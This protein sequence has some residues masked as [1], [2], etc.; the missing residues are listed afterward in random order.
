RKLKRSTVSRVRGG[1]QT[2]AMRFD[3]RAADRQAQADSCLL[4]RKK[5]LE[6]MV[7][8]FW[9]ESAAAIAD[10][11]QN[12]A[13]FGCLCRDGKLS[14][15]SRDCTHRLDSVCDEIQD[16]LLQLHAVAEDEG[17]ARLQFGFQKDMMFGQLT[18]D[19]SDD[20]KNQF[21]DAQRVFLRCGL[22]RERAN[23]C[24]YFPGAGG[25]LNDRSH[26]F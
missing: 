25:L 19:E 16:H 9:R 17:K 22:L 5:S 12:L 8:Q 21:V 7:D 18:A 24:N 26:R 6:D 10:T 11:D 13:S 4:C 20:F 2:A 15:P 1:P 23:A 3:N 14:R